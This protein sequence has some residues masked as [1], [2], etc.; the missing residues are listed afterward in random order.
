MR[1]DDL[2]EDLAHLAAAER[3]RVMW[4]EAKELLAAEEGRRSLAER[5]LGSERLELTLAGGA[6]LR[7]RGVGR[8]EDV[9]A[10]TGEGGQWL[11]A[12]AAIH[13]ARPLAATPTVG[14]WP[15]RRLDE[16]PRSLPALRAV[17]RTMARS[18]PP[19]TVH[20]VSGATEHGRL[21]GVGLDHVELRAGGGPTLLALG[22][23]AALGWAS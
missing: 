15:A 19:L 10:V 23:V 9:L 21:I 5:L 16:R 6:R 18:R 2:F 3:T 4:D 11:V 22:A 13:V 14:P 20:V 17:L 1:F 8:G 7:G 12:T